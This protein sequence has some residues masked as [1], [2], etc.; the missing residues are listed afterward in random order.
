MFASA[1]T[2]GA[3]VH[4]G[5]GKQSSS[6]TPYLRVVGHSAVGADAEIR[7]DRVPA[8][9]L[10][11]MGRF[12]LRAPSPLVDFINVRRTPIMGM[13]E[14]DFEMPS[15]AGRVNSSHKPPCA[16]RLIRLTFNFLL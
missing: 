13:G 15:G 5:A 6:K 10:D 3:K 8:I 2:V 1:K 9:Q 16:L 14:D 7:E 12:S 11:H 4:T